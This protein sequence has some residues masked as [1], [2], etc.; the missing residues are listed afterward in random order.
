MGTTCQW[1][2]TEEGVEKAWTHALEVSLAAIV[3]KG[4]FENRIASGRTRF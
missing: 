1:E 3:A 4:E 2:R